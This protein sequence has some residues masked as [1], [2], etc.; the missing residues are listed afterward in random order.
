MQRVVLS[1]RYFSIPDLA[2]LLL[3]A[4]VIYGVVAIGNEWRSDFHPLTKIDLSLWALPYYTLMSAARGIVAYL[5]S[6]TFTLIVG[7]IAANSR[8]AEK[9]ILPL[10]DILQSIPV[11]GFLPGLLLGLVALFPDTN[12]GLELA[13]IL[14]IFTGQVWN[15]TFSYYS[16]LKSVPTDMKEASSVMGLNWRER[17]VKVELPFSAVTLAWNSLLSMAGGWFFLIP[18]EAMTL[19]DR[20]YRLP[21]IGAYMDVAI[22]QGNSR[23]ILMAV[24]AMISLI[25][26]MDFVIWRPILAWVQ[27]FRLEQVSGIQ[28][29]EPIMQIWIRESKIFRWLK[30]FYRDFM[31]EY[32]YRLPRVHV[33]FRWIQKTL[34]WRLPH[35]RKALLRVRS[36]HSSPTWMTFLEV[37]GIAAAFAFIG[38]GA[39]KLLTV[40]IRVPPSTWILLIRDTLW[41]LIR[42]LLAL[43]ISTLWAVP[44]GIWVGT[45]QKRV[46]IAQPLIQ[47]MASFPA[48]MLYP[49]AL[50][51]F[52]ALRISFD[53]GAMFLMLLG[54]QWYVLFNVLAGALRI[55]QELN[56]ALSLMETSRWDRWKTLYLPSIFPFLVTGWVT[57]AGGAWNA[58][59]VAEYIFY[60]GKILKTGG[61]GATLSVATANQNFPLFAASLTVM[62]TV[63]ILLNRLLWS[64]VYRLAQTR[65]RMDL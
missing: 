13:A 11:L 33:W 47:I 43:T 51:L 59:V 35:L 26:L 48:P 31:E 24:A 39:F 22:K 63:V 17:L 50:G 5:I 36:N 29:T 34:G 52:F 58:S 8:L 44:V 65:F 16:S 6:L 41:T 10:L 61:L 15:M 38:W 54:V 40:L 1:R 57:A 49:I 62:V 3:I 42:V 45:S 14:M 19:G 20:E 25:V 53:W 21:G 4:T 56:Y 60:Q 32:R 18:C 28:K 27:R 7:Y 23:A 9:I 46:R 55:P 2:I 12:T 30:L 37:L 64:R